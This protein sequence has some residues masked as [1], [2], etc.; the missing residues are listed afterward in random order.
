MVP[1]LWPTSARGDRQAW[2]K[3]SPP[4]CAQRRTCASSAVRRDRRIC[5]SSRSS[6]F[7]AW[8]RR[9]RASGA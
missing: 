3:V 7:C 1:P 4:E 6:V 5:R 2:M 9:F 8:S